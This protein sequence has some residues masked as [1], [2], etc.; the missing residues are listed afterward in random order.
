[1]IPH[2]RRGGIRRDT[3][4][5]IS[6]TTVGGDL[7]SLERADVRLLPPALKKYYYELRSEG[8]SHEMALQA[9]KEIATD[10]N[11]KFPSEVE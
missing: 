10:P 9:V 7:S 2:Y 5:Q 8:I 11:Y 6:D 3:G 1:M 4:T